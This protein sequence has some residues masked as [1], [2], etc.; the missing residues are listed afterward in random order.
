MNYS[1]LKKIIIMLICIEFFSLSLA[2]N[3]IANIAH[4][5]ARKYALLVGGG[6]KKEDNYESFYY[7]IEYMYRGLIKIGYNEKDITVLFFGGKSTSHQ[8]V[9]GNASKK[10]FI[11]ELHRY[12]ALMD[13]NDSLLIFRSGHGIIELVFEKYGILQGEE[14][15]PEDESIKV[16]GSAAVMCFPDGPLSTFELQNRLKNIKAKQII[17]ILNQCFSGGFTDIANNIKNVVVI[18]ETDCIGLGFFSKRNIEKYKVSVWPFVKC[19][20]DGF[21]GNDKDFRKISIIEAFNH[22]I[23]CNPNVEGVGFKADRPLWTES[24]QI[25][26]GGSLIVGNVYIY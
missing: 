12:E 7:N 17:L 15:V 4:N 11:K 8:I 26:Y 5:E 2:N 19:L 23:E 21:F 3:S 25:K 9:S 6:T 13:L 1:Y 24:P 14:S 20:V 10:E 18:S 22:M 16:I